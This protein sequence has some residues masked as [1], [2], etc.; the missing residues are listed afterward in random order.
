MW[1]FRKRKY[2]YSDPFLVTT[3]GYYGEYMQ[4]RR[5]EDTGRIKLVGCSLRGIYCGGIAHHASDSIACFPPLVE[6]TP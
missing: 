5:D 1:P 3:S 6:K 4:W 2:S